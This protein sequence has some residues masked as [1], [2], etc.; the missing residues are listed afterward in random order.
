MFYVISKLI[1]VHSVSPFAQASLYYTQR[2]KHIGICSH[3]A[4]IPDIII[5]ICSCLIVGMI[6]CCDCFV[7]HNT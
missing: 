6:I 2:K 7:F 4:D 1:S 3:I 5:D